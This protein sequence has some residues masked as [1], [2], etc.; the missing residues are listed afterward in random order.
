MKFD[1]DR[2]V[3]AGPDHIILSID[4]IT[5]DSY[6]KFRKRGDLSLALA[7]VQR[8][9]AAK[10]KYGFNRP[11]LSWRF[12]TFEHNLYEVDRAIEMAREL[13]VDY[14]LISTPSDVSGDDPDVQVA[15]SEREGV[16]GFT[17]PQMTRREPRR[18]LDLLAR[19]DEVDHLFAEDWLARA[20]EESLNET[21][22]GSGTCLWLY[23]NMTVDAIGRVMPCCIV[24]K[25]Y[26]KLVFGDLSEKHPD[27]FNT[28]SYIRAR[29]SFADRR[30]FEESSDATCLWLRWSAATVLLHLS[31][32][33]S[34]HLQ[35]R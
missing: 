16:Y 19:Y 6:E 13:G 7:N 12:F 17:D 1:V 21:N 9:V 8:L 18:I 25:T 3:K 14:M 23:Y 15:T 11:I 27:P 35:P 31:Q 34:A 32:T 24:P 26:E 4:G 28:E 22:V 30:L 33:A 20:G 29:L 5:Q 2:F 10:R